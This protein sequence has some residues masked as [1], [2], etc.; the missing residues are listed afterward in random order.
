MSKKSLILFLAL[1]L[2]GFAAAQETNTN[3]GYNANIGMPDYSIF[4]EKPDE[5]KIKASLDKVKNYVIY[6]SALEFVNQK[7]GEKVASNSEPS[8][9]AVL[10]QR[11]GRFNE[12][13][14]TIGVTMAA[15]NKVTEITGD[16][17]YLKHAIAYYNFFYDFLPYFKSLDGKIRQ[18]NYANYLHLAALDHCGAEGFGL[19]KTYRK[20][21][22][23]RYLEGIKYI[24]EYISKGQ[25]R[26]DD[27]TVARQ[28][29]QPESLWADDM[30]M[31]IPLLAQLGV[32]TG[33]KKYW[34]DGVKQAIQL[35]ARLF[36]EQ[37]GLFDH[38]WNKYSGDYDP[39][40][41]W[42][43]ANGWACMSMAELLDVLPADFKGRDKVLHIFRSHIRAL[44][45]LQ[46]GSGLWHN[47]LDKTDTYL[48]TSAS[49]MFVY[50]LAKGVNEGWISHVYGPAALIGW[51]GL[52]SKILSNG[53]VDDCVEGTTYA[54]ENA[55]YYHRGRSSVNTFGAGP[56]MLAGAEVIRLLKNDKFE[57]FSNPKQTYNNAIHFKLKSDPQPK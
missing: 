33:D 25:F 18:N 20:H 34:E 47:M 23:T 16:S 2:T 48:E 40:F 37:K 46:D 42:G 32:V 35:S 52:S 55:Y 45:E 31:C 9:D 17:S 57:I 27:G 54:N 49:A 10:N 4:Y 51:N 53:Q 26:F 29:P 36:V 43:R 22:D 13:A 38:G 50:C 19:C 14:Y 5:S 6:A 1:C 21:K 44:T 30:Y 56:V 15:M 12:W 7:T 8:V 11:G 39:R 24:G 41:Y 28:R 3:Y